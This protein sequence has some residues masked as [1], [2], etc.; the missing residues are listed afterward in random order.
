MRTLLTLLPGYDEP[1][2]KAEKPTQPQLHTP[3]PEKPVPRTRV[4]VDASSSSDG[5]LE[6]IRQPEPEPVKQPDSRKISSRVA[7]WDVDQV[8]AWLTKSGAIELSEL[9]GKFKVDGTSIISLGHFSDAERT[10]FLITHLRVDPI[11]ALKFSLLIREATTA[12]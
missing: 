2:P 6:L 12:Q 3:Q 8:S 1:K 11:L 9:A 5:Q 10:S 7:H 4:P